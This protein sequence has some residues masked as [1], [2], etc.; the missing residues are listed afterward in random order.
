VRLSVLRQ[1]SRKRWVVVRSVRLRVGRTGRFA[2]RMG[3]VRALRG[4]AVRAAVLADGAARIAR[5]R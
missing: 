4:H 3:S 5:V 2:R 1:T